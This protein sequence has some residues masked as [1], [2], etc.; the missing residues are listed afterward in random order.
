MSSLAILRTAF[1]ARALAPPNVSQL[2]ATKQ[3][4]QSAALRMPYKDDMDRESFK[5]KSHENTATGTDA[6][7]A[8]QDD[9]AFNPNETDPESEM[10]TAGKGNNGNP[11]K[12][13]PADKT[14]SNAG[15]GH[16]E[17][18]SHGG[19]KK[20]SGGGDAPKKGKTA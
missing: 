12:E 20:A 8:S 11:L 15:R 17:D 13:T 2:A 5:P 19:H 18:K 14:F 3:I 9:A 4:H 7:V 1:R 10:D 6:D 16:A